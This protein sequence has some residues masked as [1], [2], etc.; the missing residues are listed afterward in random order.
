MRV[1]D[2]AG[3]TL[4]RVFTIALRDV[5]EA[6][7]AQADAARAAEAGGI[8]NATAGIDPV[9][10]VLANDS[11]PDAGDTRRVIG[12][13]V[14]GGTPSGAALGVTLQGRYGSLLLSA[15]G[16]YLYTVDNANAGR[17]GAA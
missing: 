6:V 9:G 7:D 5:N 14:A 15:D 17:A 8:G 12:V 1:T 11:D 4:D 10:N 13:A 2:T 16:R 3:A